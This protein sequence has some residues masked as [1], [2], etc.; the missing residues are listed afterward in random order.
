MA[1]KR[2]VFFRLFTA[3]FFLVLIIPGLFTVMGIQENSLEKRK[4]NDLPGLPVD[5]ET[6]RKFPSLFEDYLQ[7]HIGLKTWLNK[8]YSQ[9]LLRL[10]TSPV[11]KV[12]LGKDNWLFF[13]GERVISDFQNTELF[14]EEQLKI[15]VDSLIARQKA[16]A[17]KGINYLFVIAPNKHTIYSEYL[18]DY[19]V[20][21]QAQSRCDQL[22]DYL[23]KHTDVNFLDLRPALLQAKK[24]NILYW[25]RDTHWNRVGAAVAQKALAAKLTKMGYPSTPVA[26]DFKHW[27]HTYKRNQ[28]L[29][30]LLGGVRKIEE[31]GWSYHPDELPCGKSYSYEKT[32]GKDN[33]RVTSVLISNCPSGQHKMLMFRDS[34]SNELV[35]FLS[36]YFHEAKYL[37]ILPDEDAFKYFLSSNI[38]IVIEER[39]ER[40]LLY[41]PRPHKWIMNL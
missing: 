31:Q 32:W 28:D 40:K 4:Q 16:L 10:G 2:E 3:L 30:S 19:I 34:F 14:N 41:L 24:R 13:A 26:T 9:A 39:V 38:D 6:L 35:P 12:V 29:S 27:K 7:D 25:A 8:L 15:W 11:E 37:W 5:F 1:Y 21:K 36:N 20:K 18:P 22:T 23:Q 17:E 33:Q